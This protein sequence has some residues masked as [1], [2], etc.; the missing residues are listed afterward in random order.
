MDSA[1]NPGAATACVSCPQKREIMSRE[2]AS[3][4]LCRI[5][6][7][8]CTLPH[9]DKERLGARPALVHLMSVTE[10]TCIA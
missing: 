4:R 9:I 1:V 2:S 5:A 6:E 8:V 10:Q 7:T 3:C